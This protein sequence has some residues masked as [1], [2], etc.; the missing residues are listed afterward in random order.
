MQPEEAC[1]GL[2][3]NKELPPPLAVILQ[4]AALQ[5]GFDSTEDC[6]RVC[7]PG[8][9]A[10]GKKE[11]GRQ[12]GIGGALIWLVKGAWCWVGRREERG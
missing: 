3:A 7:G 2:V 4:S 1:D 10:L 11:A 6:M 9:M 12:L 5:R 8:G